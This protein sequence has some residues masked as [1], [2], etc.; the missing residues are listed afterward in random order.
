MLR[1]FW[2]P[3]GL[4]LLSAC[5]SLS[6]SRLESLDGETETVLVRIQDLEA[7]FRVEASPALLRIMQDPNRPLPLRA[8]AAGALAVFGN[9][10]GMA[11]CLACMVAGLEGSEKR[12]RQLG[13]PFSDRMAFA[14]ELA[15][16]SLAKFLR[17][18]GVKAPFFSANFGAPDLRQAWRHWRELLLPYMGKPK[19]SRTVSKRERRRS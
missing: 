5:S 19:T 4:V 14:R 1:S 10:K 3:L 7:S 12:D 8:R 13:I 16:R 18:K 17:G 6:S 9:P 15:S 2:I 11:F